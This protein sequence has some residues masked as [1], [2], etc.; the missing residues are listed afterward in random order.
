MGFQPGVSYQPSRALL[1][2]LR[3]PLRFLLSLSPIL[4]SPC[5]YLFMSAMS[6][7]MFSPSFS[8][9]SIQAGPDPQEVPSP[10]P[11]S[12]SSSIS[13]STST[14]TST[15]A[16]EFGVEMGIIP[17]A[18]MLSV[19]APIQVQVQHPSIPF[20]SARARLAEFER[21]REDLRKT[22]AVRERQV[23]MLHVLANEASQELDAPQVRTR[24]SSSYPSTFVFLFLRWLMLGGFVARR[25]AGLCRFCP[26]SATCLSCGPGANPS[27]GHPS[28][29]LVPTS[30]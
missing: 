13:T 12:P 11:T 7:A 27:C 28:Q 9:R 29:P 20:V 10:F 22:E 23:E 2:F 15:S 5:C 19:P 6:A 14:S 25:F 21:L 26:Y 3:S 16:Y 18:T 4:S 8:A 30:S 17:S 1:S 24:F